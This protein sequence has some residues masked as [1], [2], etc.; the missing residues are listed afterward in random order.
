MDIEF[1]QA[2]L[3]TDAVLAAADLLHHSVIISETQQKPGGQQGCYIQFRRRLSLPHDLVTASQA[4]WNF[5]MHEGLRKRFI[6]D[7]VRI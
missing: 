2:F 3:K 4:V 5:T 6:Y 7:H 1:D